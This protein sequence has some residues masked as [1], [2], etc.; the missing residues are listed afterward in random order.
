VGSKNLFLQFSRMVLSAEVTALVPFLLNPVMHCFLFRPFG[1]YPCLVG[2][3]LNE[4]G[5]KVSFV[6]V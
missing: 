1:T 5:N 2:P 6:K 3:E 4:S